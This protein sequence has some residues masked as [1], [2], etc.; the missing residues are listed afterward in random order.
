[1][2]PGSRDLDRSRPRMTPIAALPIR[3]AR[4]SDLPALLALESRFPGDRLSPRQMRHHLRNPRARLRVLSIQRQLAGYALLLLR[5]GSQIARLYSI[6]VDPAQRGAG[7]GARLLADIEVQARRAGATV[8]QLEV[9]V[10]N[11][12]AIA[13]YGRR[14][15]E[16]FA[17]IPRY[18][19][20]GAAAWRYRK[21]LRAPDDARG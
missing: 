15:Y 3:P 11:A 5:S 19:E 14:G 16:R 7:L 21:P 13:L 2:H 6:T 8:L 18:Y 1:M 12:A 17:R 20:D 10:D 4:P 9:R